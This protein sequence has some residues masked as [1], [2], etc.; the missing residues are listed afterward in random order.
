MTV[1]RLCARAVPPADQLTAMH[2][3][4][5]RTPDTARS[6]HRDDRE[7][8]SVVDSEQARISATGGLTLGVRKLVAHAVSILRLRPGDLIFTGTPCDAA[9][10]M[11]RPRYLRPGRAL[12]TYVARIATVRQGVI[13]ARS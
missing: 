10:T 9:F 7:I 12:S 8:G 6:T 5:A 3:S 11:D 1:L 13:E 4:Y 2:D